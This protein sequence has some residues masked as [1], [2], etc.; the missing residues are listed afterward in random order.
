MKE[1]IGGTPKTINVF[2]WLGE[3]HHVDDALNE[4]NLEY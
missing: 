1:K 2:Q 3:G 4:I